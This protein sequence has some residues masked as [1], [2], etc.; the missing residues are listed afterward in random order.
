[1]QAV[2]K[3]IIKFDD[4]TGD[5]SADFEGLYADSGEAIEELIIEKM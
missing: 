1:M 2:H 3:A 4:S 5:G